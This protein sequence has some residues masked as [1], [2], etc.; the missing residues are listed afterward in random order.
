[1]RK[2][3]AIGSLL[4]LVGC[5]SHKPVAPA[6]DSSAETGS[7][8]NV[9]AQSMLDRRLLRILE[10]QERL[11]QEIE[12]EAKIDKVNSGYLTQQIQ[13]LSGQ[14]ESIIADNP[15]SVVPYILYGKMLRRVGESEEAQLIFM[16]ANALDPEIAVVKQQMGNY[17]AEKGRPHEALIL[18]V[19]AISLDPEVA[20]Y[21]YGLGQL[22]YEYREKLVEDGVYTI[23][24][25]DKNMVQAFRDAAKLEPE[26]HDYQMRYC[27]SFYDQAYPDWE[28]ALAAWEDFQKKADEGVE[29]DA[30]HLHRARCLMMLGRYD[31]AESLAE[32]NV[33]PLLKTTRE[34]LLKELKERSKSPVRKYSEVP[35]E[36][37]TKT[38]TGEVGVDE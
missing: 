20:V 27:E 1:M 29:A 26:N 37:E 2:L 31:E 3:A 21:P 9:E 38:P 15:D 36:S 12:R 24:Q 33:V 19:D 23:T 6:K 14:Y 16:Q 32:K 5:S 10:T 35:V 34:H 18:Y 7:Y 22:I 13:D 17:Y 30:V 25:A 4:I 8:E 28:K 11:Y